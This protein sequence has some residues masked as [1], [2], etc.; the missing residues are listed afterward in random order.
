MCLCGIFSNR[1]LSLILVCNQEKT[2]TVLALYATSLSMH[3]RCVSLLGLLQ[4]NAIYQSGKIFASHCLEFERPRSRCPQT[5]FL[6]M[7]LIP[8]FQK[9]PPKVKCSI[10]LE[11][12]NLILRKTHLLMS[13]NF[14][15]LPKG[16]DEEQ[17]R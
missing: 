16:N 3:R 14:N 5:E 6:Q 10:I 9:A 4:L 12:T 1:F 13:S 8:A 17:Y 15:H 2:K 11:G 7:I